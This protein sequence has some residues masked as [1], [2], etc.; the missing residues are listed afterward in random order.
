MKT[1]TSKY[2]ESVKELFESLGGYNNI[3]YFTHCMTR[4]RFHLKDWTIINEEKIKKDNQLMGVSKSIATGEFQ[5]I[6]G[7]DV[8]SFY[9]D[10]CKINGFEED[11][12]NRSHLNAKQTD[13]LVKQSSEIAA[14]KKAHRKGGH[15]LT[16]FLSF[17]GKVFSPIVIPMIGYGLLLTIWSLL[18]VDWNGPK[19]SLAA[20]SHFFGEFAEILGIL[21]GSFTLFITIVLGYTVFK[22]MGGNVIYGLI[23]AI[24]LTAPGLINMGDVKVPDGESIIS[25]YPG[26]TLFGKG[27]TY[28]FKINYNGLIIPIIIVLSVGVLIERSCDRI[29]NSTAKMIISP[30]VII[31]GGYLFGLFIMAPIGMLFTNYLSIGINWLSTHYVAKYIAMPIVGALYGPLVI[32][33]LHHSLTP[34]ILQGQAAYGGT[35]LQGLI[36]IS[37]ITQGVSTIAFVCVHRRIRNLK[38]VGVSNGISAIIGGITEPSLYTVNLKHL[39]PLIGCSIGVFSGSLLFVASNTFALQGASSIFGILMFQHIAPL[40]TGVITWIGGG[41]LWGTLSILLSISV[42]FSTTFILGKTK[43]FWNRSRNILLE[44]FGEDIEELKKFTKLEWNQK[45]LI[46]KNN[47][48]EKKK[49]LK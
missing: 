17:I 34:I 39:F 29:K 15:H 41:Y 18:T 30:I 36:T 19:T 9:K 2:K 13:F 35:N 38:N 7:T 49:T 1:P 16:A 20:T 23:I 14:M 46:E 8:Q 27:I 26:W 47:N 12:K 24:V 43:Y 25:V 33:G 21:T 5:V 28:P 37:N 32:T 31:G 22:A 4:M 45:L 3:E 44:D 11:G 42:A 40:K 10:F 48:L 6:I